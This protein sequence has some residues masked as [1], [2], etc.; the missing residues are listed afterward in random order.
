MINLNY[1]NIN[2]DSTICIR[3]GM[4]ML[5]SQCHGIYQSISTLIYHGIT[6]TLPLHSKND[7][8]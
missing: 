5:I 8:A 3:G 7:H 4:D 2:H 1:G 6:I